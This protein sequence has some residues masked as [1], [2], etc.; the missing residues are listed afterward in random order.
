MRRCGKRA[1]DGELLARDTTAFD[2]RHDRAVERRLEQLNPVM[3][4]DEKIGNEVH[5]VVEIDPIRGGA[6]GAVGATA[7]EA[8]QQCGQVVDNDGLNVGWY[9]RL[10]RNRGHVVVQQESSVGRLD[11]AEQLRHQ[12]TPEVAG[13][14]HD[15][16]E[17]GGDR[18]LEPGNFPALCNQALP[19]EGGASIDPHVHAAGD[20]PLEVMLL[21]R[22]ELQRA[23]QDELAPGR[24][25]RLLH[26]V[27][28]E[29]EPGAEA[30]DAFER[31]RTLAH[32]E[33]TG[34]GR[35]DI[36]R[37]GPVAGNESRC[38]GSDLREHLGVAVGQIQGTRTQE[39]TD[40]ID[41]VIGGDQVEALGEQLPL[42]SFVD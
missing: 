31:G 17:R 33:H 7:V 28:P 18:R 36:D 26:G 35:G 20:R 22:A 25:S 32:L 24:R 16:V 3:A 19:V 41:D 8:S 38:G 5:T 29:R 9:E 10:P 2:V 30:V 15:G 11:G 23:G 34:T 27:T 1:A 21:V 40:D 6:S 12:I 39:F 13:G 37:L 14:L 4:G 42:W